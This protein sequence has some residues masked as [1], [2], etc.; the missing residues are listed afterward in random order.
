M[1][2][3]DKQLK[4]SDW[5]TLLADGGPAGDATPNPNLQ[6]SFYNRQFEILDPAAARL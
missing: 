2:R 5:N 3:S 4:S 1:V 6:F